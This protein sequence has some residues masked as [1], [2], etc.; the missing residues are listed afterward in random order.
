VY[1]ERCFLILHPKF[2]SVNF[3]RYL[4]ELLLENETVI[5]PGFGAF[6]SEYKPAE[7]NTETDEIAPPSKVISFT[8]QIKNNDGLLVGYVAE[9]LNISH[10]DALLRIEK[11]REN[12]LYQLD[13]GEQVHIES[14]GTL[15]YTEQ[16]TIAFTQEGSENL[17]LD[18]FGLETTNISATE[19]A[20]VQEEEKE[21]IPAAI[22]PTEETEEVSAPEDAEEQVTEEEPVQEEQEKT[23][24]D[25]VPEEKQEEVEEEI[26][27]EIPTPEPVPEPANSIDT[28]PGK[29]EEKKKR[30]WMWLLVLI[31]LVAVSGYFFINGN[32]NNSNRTKAEEN[33][34]NITEAQDTMASH[35]TIQADS[36]A[37]LAQDSA[38]IEE[39]EQDAV[40]E[41]ESQSPKYYLVGG[42]FSVQENADT[43]LNELKAKGFDAFHAGQK[44][45]FYCIGIGVFDTFSEAEKAQKEYLT[46]NPDMELWIWRK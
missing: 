43:Y 17:L 25:D 6:I 13:K 15:F 7:I 14:V 19:P 41:T 1:S 28:V 16:H 18:S 40:K 30:A 5:I 20:E 32:K 37:I 45:K 8:Q 44:G 24:T 3:K 46:T 26:K 35:D 33:S 12:I 21:E 34:I 38:K 23:I 4:Y 36:S 42:S 22:I 27:E 2:F 29:E 10:F 39:Q 9:N 31:P 11:E